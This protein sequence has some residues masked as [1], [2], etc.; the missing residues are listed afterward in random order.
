MGFESIRMGFV[1]SWEFSTG[2]LDCDEMGEIRP[3]HLESISIVELGRQTKVSQSGL[4]THRKAVTDRS[5]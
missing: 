2:L 3:I 5:A 1:P 4:I